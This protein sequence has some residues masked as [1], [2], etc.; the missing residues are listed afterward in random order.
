MD[1]NH[2]SLDFHCFCFASTVKILSYDTTSS[3]NLRD[4][5]SQAHTPNLVVNSCE[6]SSKDTSLLKK[7]K[8]LPVII[9]K[10]LNAK[11][12]KDDDKIE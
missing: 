1:P 6:D 10:D 7:V 3:H 9:A 5:S 4:I 11:D 12:D 8:G 2:T